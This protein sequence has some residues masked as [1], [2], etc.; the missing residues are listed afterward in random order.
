MRSNVA[1]GRRSAG[2]TLVALVLLGSVACVGAQPS[3]T[4][5]LPAAQATADEHDE[6]AAQSSANPATDLATSTPGSTVPST[7][8]ALAAPGCGPSALGVLN[9][10]RPADLSHHVG[11]TP[12]LPSRPDLMSCPTLPTSGSAR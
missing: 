2:V 3:S 5:P 6:T 12:A 10:E 11:G 1:L 4:A 9:D 8:P 7:A